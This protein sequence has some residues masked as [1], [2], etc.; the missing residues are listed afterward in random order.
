MRKLTSHFHITLDGFMADPAGGMDWIGAR[1]DEETWDDVADGMKNTDCVL[2][3]RKTYGMF[4]GYWPVAENDP[5]AGPRDRGFAKWI[6]DTEKVVFTRTL[7]DAGWRKARVAKDPV[8]DVK[9]LKEKPGNNL[10]VFG[11]QSLVATLWNAGL[12]DELRLHLHP[13]AIGQGISFS[14][15]FEQKEW[16]VERTKPLKNGIMSLTFRKL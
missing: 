8:A 3:G 16:K 13:V 11:S 15:G 12:V 9:A 2:F 6:G 4:V 1:H 7:K 10:L 5:K 14:R